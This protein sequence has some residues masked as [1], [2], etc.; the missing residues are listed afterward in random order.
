MGNAFSSRVAEPRAI[1]ITGCDSGFGRETTLKLLERPDLHVISGCYTERGRESLQD[2]QASDLGMY[3]GRL[4]TVLLDVTKEESISTFTKV[5]EEIVPEGIFALINNAGILE[6][7]P[8]ELLPPT[9]HRQV[10]EVNYFGASS[11]TYSLL[12]SLRRHASR[13]PVPSLLSVT[14]PPRPR[15]INI[16]SMA[17]RTICPSLSAYSA[18]KHALKALTEAL[19]IELKSFGVDVVIVE[20][21]FAGTEMVKGIAG[22]V[23]RVKGIWERC[24]EERVGAYGVARGLAEAIVGR[25]RDVGGSFF[26][27]GPKQVVNCI[28]AAVLRRK[29]ATRYVVGV[30]SY[31]ILFAQSITPTWLADIV[32]ALVVHAD[33]SEKRLG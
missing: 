8:F 26:T 30:L 4:T 10:F 9:L 2:E 21:L 33:R 18:S 19:R 15:I 25:W 32:S 27:L 23:E 11:M 29:P 6:V 7:G 20:P 28:A 24:G 22:G 13:L 1:V 17:G 31:V 14:T 16:S 3:K 12:P 5:V